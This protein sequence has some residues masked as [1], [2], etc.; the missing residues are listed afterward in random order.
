[1]RVTWY[2]RNI[3]IGLLLL[4]LFAAAMKLAVDVTQGIAM[5][6]FA[7]LAYLSIDV[8]LSVNPAVWQR[9]RRRRPAA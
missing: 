2:P 5:G 3:A 8:L 6:V 1:M 7:A 9:L 4:A